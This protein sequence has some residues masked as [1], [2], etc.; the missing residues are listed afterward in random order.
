MFQARMKSMQYRTGG[1]PL[2]GARRFGWQLH[3]HCVYRHFCAFVMSV[4]VCVCVCVCVRDT[5]ACVYITIR[6]LSG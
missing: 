3:K 1:A 2:P 4:S 5:C 6:M